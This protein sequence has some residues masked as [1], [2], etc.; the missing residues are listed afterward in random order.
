MPTADVKTELRWEEALAFPQT[1]SV[2]AR[3]SYSYG[4]GQSSVID[5]RGLGH[6]GRR[7][8]GGR[9]APRGLGVGEGVKHELA[10]GEGGVDGEVGVSCS[11]ADWAGC[12]TVA[13][14]VATV[15]EFG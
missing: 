12:R 4:Q 9:F 2:T 15:A 11:E 5:Q 13:G 14:A 10:P 3:D 6:G 7:S 1:V 8:S